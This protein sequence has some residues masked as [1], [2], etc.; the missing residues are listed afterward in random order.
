MAAI[1]TPPDE[2]VIYSPFGAPSS[3][4]AA[5]A[6]LR[7]LDAEASEVEGTVT[8]ALPNARFRIELGD[9][10]EVV[11]HVA[12]GLRLGIGRILP[13]DRVRWWLFRGSTARVDGLRAAHAEAVML[14]R[15]ARAAAWRLAGG[16]GRRWHGGQVQRVRR[17]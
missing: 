12:A 17:S 2:H 8:E 1:V 7:C 5:R 15:G 13:G 11:A 4:H 14:K 3:I 16:T 9:G 6:R 10:S